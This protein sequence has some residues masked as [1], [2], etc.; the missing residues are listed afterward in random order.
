M[1][2]QE[3]ECMDTTN[4]IKIES[5]KNECNDIGKISGIYLILNK[6]NNK[7]YVG[8]SK[9]IK[10]RWKK[11]KQR[12][13]HNTHHNIKL[14]NAWNKYGEDNF[15]FH[16]VELAE[17]SQLL[18]VEQK[19]LDWCKLYSDTNYII[20]YDSLSQM[21][22]AK[23]LKTI[24]D[25]VK[26]NIE[27]HESGWRK[28]IYTSEVCK[29]ISEGNKLWYSELSVEEKLLMNKH[30]GDSV[31]GKLNYKNCNKTI[32]SF[33]N[34]HTNETFTGIKRDFIK[35]F[36]LNCGRVWLLVNG[37]AKTHAGWKLL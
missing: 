24:S 23:W 10:S 1:N 15:E 3:L 7:Y 9:T 28:S 33:I 5:L 16:V 27:K 6:I 31:R 18:L 12:L 14:Q 19:Y 25:N 11:H 35:K 2:N 8:S 30:I 20:N 34:V 4:D 36:N 37:R 13:R 32:T 26:L 21:D 17:E 29:K 22:R